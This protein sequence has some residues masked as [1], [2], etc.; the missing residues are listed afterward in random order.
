MTLWTAAVAGLAVAA[1]AFAVHVSRRL[2]HAVGQAQRRADLLATVARAARGQLEPS[3]VTTTVEDTL[4]QLGFD[5]DDPLAEAATARAATSGDTVVLEEGDAVA[6]AVP[7]RCRG[8]IATVVAGTCR[9]ASV[10]A[11]EVEALELLATAAG[12]ALETAEAFEGLAAA[13]RTQ[14]DF[15]STVSH[16]L[17]TPL[18]IIRGMLETVDT[19]WE[20]LDD[21]TRREFVA[22]AGVNAL[23]LDDI[24]R[25]LLDLARLDA[26]RVEVRPSIIDL[27]ELVGTVTDRLRAILAAHDVDVR[28]DASALVTGDPVLVERVIENLLTNA[29]KYTPDGGHISVSTLRL[30]DGTVELAVTDDGPGITAGSLVRLGERF[31]RAEEETAR[32]ARGV[33]LG[34]AFCREVLE[35]HGSELRV[36]TAVGRGSRFAFRLPAV[37]VAAHS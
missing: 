22:R 32:P 30:A 15:L 28:D 11:D 37:E 4:R 2:R 12:H 13:D 24:I 17:R 1:V 10:G 23:T 3:S 27:G 21:A 19:R 5:P 6:V 20:Q 9:V 35:L 26:G 31:F 16:E 36:H 33:G 18:T 34:L 25:T 7:V 14:R 8:E 29:A